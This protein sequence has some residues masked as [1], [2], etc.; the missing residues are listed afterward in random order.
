MQKKGG[1]GMMR[2]M[3]KRSRCCLNEM[4]G[5]KEKRAEKETERKKPLLNNGHADLVALGLTTVEIKFARTHS[6][7][8]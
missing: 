8:A 7:S 4:N 5:K 6:N 1:E 3:W 2:K